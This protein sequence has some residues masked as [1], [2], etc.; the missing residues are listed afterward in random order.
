MILC[1]RDFSHWTLEFHR[2]P[3]PR[4]HWRRAGRRRLRRSVS[5]SNLTPIF[6]HGCSPGQSAG[7]TTGRWFSAPRSG[8]ET[9]ALWYDWSGNC[10]HRRQ[11]GAGNRLIQH[12]QVER[13]RVSEGAAGQQGVRVCRRTPREKYHIPTEPTGSLPFGTPST[14]RETFPSLIPG[15]SEVQSPDGPPRNFPFHDGKNGVTLD[16]GKW[17]EP[18]VATQCR[19]PPSCRPQ[20]PAL[21]HPRPCHHPAICPGHHRGRIHVP[22]LHSPRWDGCR[23]GE[24]HGGKGEE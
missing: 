23:V 21:C 22:I 9:G 20:S 3:A 1:M 17:S 14:T 18:R 11:G 16:T 15:P 10:I 19:I 6:S 8:F 2:R 24:D 4:D 5:S 7:W 13:R 12:H